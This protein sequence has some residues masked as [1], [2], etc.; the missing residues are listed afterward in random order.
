[1]TGVAA[2]IAEA[3]LWIAGGYLA[4]ISIYMLL[5]AIGA[6]FYRPPRA[7]VQLQPRI[8]VLVPAHNEAAGIGT[9]ILDM[10]AV[11]YPADKVTVFIIADNCT[12]ET[13]AVAR[14][15]GATVAERFDDANRGKGHALD[16][17]LSVHKDALA[18]YDLIAF[19]DADM[20]VDKGFLQGLAEAFAHDKV[21]AV[22]GRYTVSNPEA[23][24]RSA[25]GYMSFA[26]VNHVRPAGRSFWGGTAELKGSG[27]AFR[28]DLILETGWPAHSITEDIDFG[29][30][31]LFRGI[32]VH[33]APHAIVTSDMATTASQA[34]VQ[35]SRWE[36]GNL[37]VFRRF[38]GQ[39]VGAFL[40]RPRIALLDAALDLCVPPL[41][42]VV[43]MTVTGLAVAPFLPGVPVAVFGAPV[44]AFGAAVL[45]GLIQLRAPA[46]VWLYIAAAPV[47]VLW[48]LA[49]L[50]RVA[51]GPA[52]TEWKRTPRDAELEQEKNNPPDA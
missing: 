14:E 36:G 39:T 7:T 48:K 13:A 5:I 49:L 40:R 18:E 27:M 37:Y 9:T 25:L 43:L 42:I 22:Q 31:L 10:M 32:L 52:E 23:S 45:T 19:I 50:F 4:V 15:A 47:F 3:L 17:F 26:Y 51:A 1:M 33:Y 30:D 6:W 21:E 44:A 28:R 12:D 11:E 29:K 41:S 16:W 35:Q 8:A 34:A 24:W 46:K 20:F 2:T 38:F